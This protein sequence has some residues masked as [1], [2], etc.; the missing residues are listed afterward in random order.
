[1]F[2]LLVWHSDSCTENNEALENKW[3]HYTHTHAHSPSSLPACL[4]RHIHHEDLLSYRWKTILFSSSVLTYNHTVWGSVTAMFGIFMWKPTLKVLLKW[5]H[6]ANSICQ[7]SIWG[8]KILTPLC[9][10]YPSFYAAWQ[11][12]VLTRGKKQTKPHLWWL[13]LIEAH[14]PFGAPDSGSPQEVHT[15]GRAKCGAQRGGGRQ[16]GKSLFFTVLISSSLTGQK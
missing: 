4:Y 10:T 13:D 8:L 6:C 12:H 3:D 7:G 11:R 15:R 2:Q 14:I 16:G 9:I 1:M 5:R